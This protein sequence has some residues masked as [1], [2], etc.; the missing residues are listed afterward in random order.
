[1]LAGVVLAGVGYRAPDLRSALVFAIFGVAVLLGQPG[2]ADLQWRLRVVRVRRKWLRR[3]E[4]AHGVKHIPRKLLRRLG[5]T[6]GL[7]VGHVN[8]T[9]PT[10]ARQTCLPGSPG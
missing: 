1:M 4:V 5:V 9:L 8:R 2:A 3:V 7:E 10:P 6:R